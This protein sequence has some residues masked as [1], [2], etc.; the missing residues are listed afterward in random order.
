MTRYHIPGTDYVRESTGYPLPILFPATRGTPLSL[1]F[2]Y[3]TRPG[4]SQSAAPAAAAALVFPNRVVVHFKRHYSTW[5]GE[6]LIIRLERGRQQTEWACLCIAMRIEG[7]VLMA[8]SRALRWSKVLPRAFFCCSSKRARAGGDAKNT[9]TKSK[10]GGSSS[11]TAS[12]SASKSGSGSS[13]KS[14]S[15]RSSRSSS[16]SSCDDNVSARERRSMVVR[17]SK[18]AIAAATAGVSPE[19]AVRLFD[20]ALKLRLAL[21]TEVSF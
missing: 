16:G 21:F 18:E 9:A 17:E 3:K 14:G 5:F 1:P 8:R 19:D 15:S 11:T 6:G 10:M 12:S 13:S 2:L 7:G 20:V 4:P